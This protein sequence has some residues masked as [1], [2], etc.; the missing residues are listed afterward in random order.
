MNSTYYF[1]DKNENHL[2]IEIAKR[3]NIISSFF[4]ILSGL[5][6]NFIIIFV[7]SQKRFRSNSSNVYL[8]ILAINDSLILIV[9]FFEEIVKNYERLFI[10]DDNLQINLSNN[11]TVSSFNALVLE[12]NITDN[13]D[14]ACRLIS[15]LRYVL[16]FISAYVIVAFTIQ[17][18]IVV[19]LPLNNKFKTKSSAWSTTLL[20]VF[21]S[22]F[23]NLWVLFM[24]E[25]KQSES[26]VYCD[27]NQNLNIEYMILT[28][29]YITLIM[30]IPI[31]IVF[32]SNSII[33]F[34]TRKSELLSRNAVSEHRSVQ[35]N[36]RSLII[37]EDEIKISDKRE[38]IPEQTYLTKPFYMNINQ[39]ISRISHKSSDQK[40]LTKVFS[41]ISLSFAFLNL[42]YFIAWILFYYEYHFSRTA[43][44]SRLNYINS[45]VKLTEIFYILNYGIHFWIYLAT[46]SVFRQQ[47]KYSCKFIV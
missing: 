28:I 17:R 39:I 33:L 26:F 44:E 31:S 30:F 36:V 34:E 35:G 21:T 20:I 18:L 38:K 3:I 45:F 43:K 6:G 4:I 22:I 46:S 9:H 41:W 5:I 25:L 2:F 23:I 8:F 37:A 7:F 47:L 29:I 11:I 14:L 12:L 42:P 10:H 16:R 27:S 13:Y 1:D 24:F 40:K 32:I 15:Y 19:Y